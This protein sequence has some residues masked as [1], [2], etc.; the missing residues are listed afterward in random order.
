V[1]DKRNHGEKEKEGKLK[2]M[3]TWPREVLKKSKDIEE[4]NWNSLEIYKR[5]RG[6]PHAVAVQ[7]EFGGF[8]ATEK[9]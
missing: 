4:K 9:P 5:Y 3:S 8:V 6:E 2:N 1:T 7:G